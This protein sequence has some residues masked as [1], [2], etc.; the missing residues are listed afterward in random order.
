MDPSAWKK[1]VP[2]IQ[3]GDPV[4]ADT[5][6]APHFTLA[7]QVA[8]LKTILEGIESG[9]QILIRD[10][11]LAEDIAE[12]TVVYF[13][14][15]DL[16]HD[17]AQA[18]WKTLDTSDSLITPDDSA[19]YTGV[20]ATKSA[21][22]SGCII[23]S[24]VITLSDAAITVLFNGETPEAEF[25]YLSSLVP[26]TV[27]VETPAM[28]VRVLQYLGGNAIRVLQ[29]DPLPMTHTHKAFALDMAKWIPVG[30]FDPDIVPVGATE[31]YD[32]TGDTQNLEEIL[33]P[34]VGEG[35]FVYVDGA[36][37]GLHIP[38]TTVYIDANGI[39]WTSGSSPTGDIEVTVTVADTHGVAVLHSIAS[40]D[41][42]SIVITVDNGRVLVT[43][44]DFA[45]SVDNAGSTVIKDI[46]GHTKIR[47]EVVEKILAG[48]GTKVTPTSGQG[49]VTIENL[50]LADPLLPAE[51]MNLNNS[52]TTT[53]G[54]LVFTQLPVDR[55]SSISGRRSLPTLE[56]DSLYEAVIWARCLGVGSAVP[57][58][59]LKDVTVIPTAVAYPGG[60]TPAVAIASETMP[61]IPA[62]AG[63]VFFIENP[64]AID[65]T[66]ASAGE[67]HY[68]LRLDNPDDPAKILNSGVFVR[69]KP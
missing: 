45:D 61:D 65:L 2:V 5:A 68:T 40:G 14:G 44:Q 56:D 21:A 57:D 47:G 32:F 7:E 43:F 30:S 8:A 22:T 11:A 67:I 9:E 28:S 46:V 63:D 55:D 37:Q 52:I 16:L 20:V 64:T 41:T 15:D 25:Y 29:P 18:V 69:L 4:S 38:G 59:E 34:A 13:S 10:A 50:T 53:E 35:S 42:D 3:D 24:G 51:I 36:D 31:G 54:A 49:T 26:G 66:G 23:M 39:W 19:M 17:K 12:G 33:L 58:I 1:G 6:N 27:Q 48:I 62:G 60:V